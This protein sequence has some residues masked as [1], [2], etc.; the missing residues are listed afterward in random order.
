[1]TTEVAA[2]HVVLDAKIA[3]LTSGLAAADAQVRGF[4]GRADATAAKAG[5]AWRRMGVLMAKGALVGAGAA[6]A[7][8]VSAVKTASDFETRLSQLQA[9]SEASASEMDAM[10]ESALDLGAS[11]KFSAREVAEAQVELAK[12]GMDVS[13]VLGGSLKA[14]L[15]L[16]AAGEIELAQASETVVNTM[17]QFGLSG[18]EAIHIADALA[19][20]ANATTADVDDMA[21]ALENAGPM[22]KNAGL[23]FDQTVVALELLA[24]SGTKGAEAGTT[25]RSMLTQ[26]S[27]P[28]KKSTELMKELG[29]EFFDAQGNF[30]DMA[31]VS[32]ML[33]KS[34]A[35]LNA[36]QR[37]Q[38]A[39]TIAGTYGQKALLAIMA[40]GPKLA[41]EYTKGLQKQGQAAKVAETMNDNLAGKL[42]QLGG[43][44]ETIQIRIGS[45]LIPIISDA[46]VATAE[47]LD[48]LGDSEGM[49]AF[50][51]G[52]ADALKDFGTAAM[53]AWGELQPFLVQLGD[54]GATAFSGMQSAASGAAPV[55]QT[56]AGLLGDVASGALSLVG[57]VAS[58]TAALAGLPGVSQAATAGL[59]GLGAAFVTFKSATAGMTLAGVV[60]SILAT[61]AA[62][63][64]VA[65]AAAQAA[66]AQAAFAAATQRSQI[67]AA[68][69]ALRYQQVFAGAVSATTKAQFVAA[70]SARTFGTTFATSTAKAASSGSRLGT[71]MTAVG[72][73]FPAVGA[74]AAAIASPLG[75]AAIGVAG[76]TAGL[77]T[78]ATV[79]ES[80]AERTAN[81]MNRVADATRNADSAMR[82]FTSAT[83]TLKDAV[84]A[85]EAALINK[86]RAQARVNELEAAGKKGTLDYRAAVND[87]ARAT[88][89]HNK[90]R[91]T[92]SKAAQASR[93][94]AFSSIAAFS[95]LAS[96]VDNSKMSIQDQ[97]QTIRTLSK[98]LNLT[99]QAG[100]ALVK[101]WVEIDKAG[102][103][104]ADKLNVLRSTLRDTA[105]QLREAGKID[106]AKQLERLGRLDNSQLLAFGDAFTDLI[107]KGEGVPQAIS[108]AFAGIKPPKSL[109]LDVKDA[110]SPKADA[111]AR[112]MNLVRQ[113]TPALLQ[114]QDLISPQLP[115]IQSRVDS[116]RGKTIQV[117]VDVDWPAGSPRAYEI[118]DVM[119]EIRDKSV[120][121]TVNPRGT[122]K[123]E[124]MAKTLRAV[125]P[126]NL[127]GLRSRYGGGSLD[128]LQEALG[129]AGG[130]LIRADLQVDN[131]PEVL[132]EARE[133]GL[134]VG[135]DFGKAIDSQRKALARTVGQSNELIRRIEQLRS[136]T[137][138]LAQA[139]GNVRTSRGDAGQR[140]QAQAEVKRI[141]R[142]VAQ[143]QAAFRKLAGGRGA[144]DA[145]AR[146]DRTIAVQI[147][148]L[149]GRAGELRERAEEMRAAKE[150]AFEAMSTSTLAA[151][152]EQTSRQMERIA[153]KFEDGYRLIGGVFELVPG[154][155]RKAEER[156]KAE[157]GRLQGTL[158]A[159]MRRIED[160]Y[161]QRGK[162]LDGALSVE[163]DALEA[164]Y[165]AQ[166]RAVD[167]RNQALTA[168]ERELASLREGNAAE[169][170]ARAIREAEEALREAVAKRMP[171]A[172]VERRM[173]AVEEARLAERIA[174]LEK[175]A[176]V[177]RAAADAQAEAEKAAWEK[178]R[179]VAR[180]GL[181]E[182]H[183]TL[184]DALRSE[185]EIERSAAQSRYDAA[186][187]ALNRRAEAERLYWQRQLQ[188]EQAS[189]QAL[190]DAE[191]AS[192]E[193]S[194]DQWRRGLGSIRS[195][196]GGNHASVLAQ[197]NDFAGR[198][199]KSGRRLGAEY[200]QGLRESFPELRAAASAGADII[201]RY[202]RLNSPAEAGALASLDRWWAPFADTLLSGMDM[203]ATEDLMA[204]YADPMRGGGMPVPA[205]GGAPVVVNLNVSVEDRTFAGMSRDQARRVAQQIGPELD[206]RVS[207]RIP[208]A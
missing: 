34:F 48:A 70:T 16:A 44:I 189:L 76:L 136:L 38:A 28:T 155:F 126:G 75:I 26:L 7:G 85:E 201:A 71:I 72:Q 99:P 133:V 145:L 18:G 196:V 169:D 86:Q 125:S 157:A 2:A 146:F 114:A 37:S 23:S 35:K 113:R 57:P 31:S 58:A 20:A 171:E 59:I 117:T 1:M 165:D 84:I 191:R 168:A 90:A 152:D 193:A 203:R 197:V 98:S 118:P 121:V 160:I 120:T 56:T 186:V 176:E 27:N 24:K 119:R 128:P 87:L 111:A 151:F 205:A 9:V 19:E 142:Q 192:L 143:A 130:L 52:A 183:E 181:D 12:A 198:L 40:G 45:A 73:R 95:K 66:A 148:N 199:E 158:D 166:I 149:G 54:I 36:E 29:I 47:W 156:V 116:L 17:G 202:L 92:E 204:R 184:R 208:A 123:L 177:E 80:S 195:V 206:R 167:Q 127:Q 93:K 41:R 190:R 187:E 68:T 14:S 43:A 96:T 103:S 154:E 42:E 159:E 69:S 53:V 129:A 141:T 132:A 180:A 83:Q 179:E 21:Q 101:K 97:V 173:R 82:G 8:F 138:Q 153:S 11:T 64:A 140:G 88:N 131:L 74:A 67:I 106:A 162:A 135:G 30:K 161:K 134:T 174:G 139:K 194:L 107:A 150:R 164:A 51:E 10:R 3:G 46:A 207:A 163:T 170:R 147:R 49:A 124:Q 39:S 62:L 22:A 81:A 109:K 89:E 33:R 122:G 110:I 108:K 91:A 4:A 188:D 137:D 50:A 175:Q 105:A 182:R 200:A 5:V 6:A 102:G 32:S 178:Q 61:A 100:Q 25:V 63:R 79:S 104:A 94:E 55:L 112:K 60:S 78:L 13:E 144:A 185:E 115:A 77:V 65:P 15:A 172:E